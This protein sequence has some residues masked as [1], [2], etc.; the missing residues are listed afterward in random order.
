MPAPRVDGVFVRDLRLSALRRNGMPAPRLV[1]HAPAVA[2][3]PRGRIVMA[4]VSGP[5]I[6][7][8]A[9]VWRDDCDKGA[10]MTLPAEIP[11]TPVQLRALLLTILDGRPFLQSAGVNPETAAMVVVWRP[12]A[13]RQG[14][15]SVHVPLERSRLG[16]AQR[17]VEHLLSQMDLG[18][19]PSQADAEELFG[20]LDRRRVAAE[21]DRS[22]YDGITPADAL[23]PEVEGRPKGRPSDVNDLT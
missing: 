20:L 1:R 17:L 19:P 18:L 23:A 10:T 7:R 13:E 15:R 12:E 5:P 22:D 16:E 4:V 6:D 8:M 21:S 14:Y 11:E 2:Q 9:R 3:R